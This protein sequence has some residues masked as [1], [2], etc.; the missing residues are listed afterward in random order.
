MSLE[1]NLTAFGLSEILQLIAVQQKSGMLAISSQDRA[2]VLFFREG[3][4]MS[5]RDRRRKTKDP[6]KDYLTRYGILSREDLL[7]LT[8]IGAQ[9]KLDMT[10]IVTSEGF[11][12][13]DE[14]D[15]HYRNHIQ[16]EVHELLTWEQCSYK[17]I[18]GDDV[19]DG[20][21]N[22]GEFSIEGMLMESMR[23]IDEFPSMLEQFPDL[24]TLITIVKEP[25]EDEELT[26][27]GRAM[28]ALLDKERALGHLISHGKV[29]RFDVYEALKHLKDKGIIDAT[30]DQELEIIEAEHIAATKVETRRNRNFFPVLVVLALFGSSAFWGAKTVAPHIK[31]I[32]ARGGQVNKVPTIERS[33]VES[34][35]RFKLDAYRAVHGA[36]PSALQLLRKSELANK[37]F[38]DRVNTHAFRYHLT[39][40]GT[41]Y[42]LL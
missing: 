17:F 9:S 21:K 26:T 39:A 37:A 4:I 34:E 40:D 35:L 6:L 18:P 11:I 13:T 3:K 19:I 28:L 41:R 2:K 22:L 12:D 24:G 30:F 7:R 8:Q 25:E 10:D 27:T 23:R 20:I 32:Q 15:I 29:P 38:L 16:E 5:T 1:G 14:L 31:M 42:T 33:R 36:Y